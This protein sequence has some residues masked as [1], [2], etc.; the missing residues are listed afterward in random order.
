MRVVQKEERNEDEKIRDFFYRGEERRIET[1]GIQLE[2][3]KWTKT[4]G[5]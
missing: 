3:T 2:D 1:D 5:E 4:D